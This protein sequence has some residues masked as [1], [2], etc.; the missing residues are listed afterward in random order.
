[1]NSVVTHEQERFLA[2]LADIHALSTRELVG[3]R[4]LVCGKNSFKGFV[5]YVRSIVEAK[6]TAF[7][8]LDANHRVEPLP[9]KDIVD[10]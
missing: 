6:E 5:G 8:D 4:V 3:R 7:V 10:L 1:V 2:E 9:F